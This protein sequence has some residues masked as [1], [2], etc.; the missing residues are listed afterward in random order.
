MGNNI[1]LPWVSE[2]ASEPS[3]EPTGPVCGPQSG[4]WQT[5]VLALPS[6]LLLPREHP[7]SSTLTGISQIFTHLGRTTASLETHRYSY[8]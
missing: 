1:S 6:A 8:L 2:M 7:S 3:A 5:L 4:G